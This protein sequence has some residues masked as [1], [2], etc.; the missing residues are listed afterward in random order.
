MIITVIIMCTINIQMNGAKCSKQVKEKATFTGIIAMDPAGP[1]FE[2]N[3]KGVYYTH[4]QIIHIFPKYIS[5]NY[6]ISLK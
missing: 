2:T 3:S 6:E 5:S 4:T 1:I